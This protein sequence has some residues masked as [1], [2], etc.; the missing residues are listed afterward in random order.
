MEGFL[1]IFFTRA[2]WVLQNE[3]NDPGSSNVALQL[4]LWQQSWSVSKVASMLRI[5]KLPQ[6]LLHRLHRYKSTDTSRIPTRAAILNGLMEDGEFD[7]LIDW[8]RA[9]GSGRSNPCFP[10]VT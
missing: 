3:C 10:Y 7:L 1:L 4:A 9:T 5:R 6:P 2:I 8:G